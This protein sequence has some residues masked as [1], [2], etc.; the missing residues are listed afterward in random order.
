MQRVLMASLVFV[1][2]CVAASG[3]ESFIVRSNL[4][5]AVGAACEFTPSVDAPSI[6]R[7]QLFLDSPTPYVF[8]PLLESRITA[9]QGKESLRTII[10]TGANVDLQIGPT[11]RID[12]AGNVT[13]DDTVATASFK[14]LFTTPLPPNGGLATG[15]FD[16][17]PL[18]AVSE[19]RAH[20]GA[21]G[22]GEHVHSQV[23]ATATILGDYYGDEIE[24]S[25]FQF[26]VTL[27]NDCVV[28]DLG[29]CATLQ[30]STTVRPGNA[31]N[32]FQDGIVDCCEDLTNNTFICPA[33]GGAPPPQ[34]G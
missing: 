14:S 30:M 9:A 16:L 4:A 2:G 8:N 23:I 13:I 34:G 6:A 21:I 29:D 19:L 31:C 3:D 33:I 22:S 32:V 1:G 18:S 12:A 28:N 24:S 11:E 5:P 27:C 20:L 10:V 15:Q 7:G 25:P 26:P 17:V